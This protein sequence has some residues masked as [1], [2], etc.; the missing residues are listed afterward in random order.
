LLFFILDLIYFLVF[1]FSIS[2][3]IFLKK[4]NTSEWLIY[5]FFC[6]FNFT[7]EGTG[8]ILHEIYDI[9][10]FLFFDYYPFIP[11]SLLVWVMLRYVLIKNNKISII[12]LCIYII[13][14]SYINVITTSPNLIYSN[15]LFDLVIILLSLLIIQQYLFNENLQIKI[16]FAF[17]FSLLNLTYFSLMLFRELSMDFQM[18][19]IL[20]KKLTNQLLLITFLLNIVYYIIYSLI[21]YK[22]AR[23][24]DVSIKIEVN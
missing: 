22:E 14:L 17:K 16:N 12:L 4:K 5:W 6:F 3:I 19:L 13:I 23:R 20:N 8:L 1:I 21:L 7:L 2:S 10:D 15:S 11:G 18:L 9:N 24:K